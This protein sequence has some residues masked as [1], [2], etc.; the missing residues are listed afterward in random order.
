MNATT[1]SHRPSSRRLQEIHERIHQGEFPALTREEWGSVQDIITNMDFWCYLEA[2]LL[3]FTFSI[4]EYAEGHCSAKPVLSIESS[5]FPD[6]RPQKELVEMLS[7]FTHTTR[8]SN[9]IRS[10]GFAPLKEPS[11]YVS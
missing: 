6:S 3:G 11:Y 1:A 9:A 2:Y 5:Q 10:H 8:N 7:V 4:Y